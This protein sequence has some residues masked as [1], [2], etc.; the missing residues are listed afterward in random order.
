MIDMERD[1]R[2]SVLL[3]LVALSL[4]LVGRAGAIDVAS[5]VGDWTLSVTRSGVIKLA[6]LEL[7]ENSGNLQGRLFSQLGDASIGSARIEN[8]ALSLHY[9]VVL[10]DRSE[11]VR[12][13]LQ[14]DYAALVHMRSPEL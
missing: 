6:R 8:G 3:L 11:E 9:D 5:V 4:L 1:G 7:R 12:V 14:Q 10:G 13:I 2:R